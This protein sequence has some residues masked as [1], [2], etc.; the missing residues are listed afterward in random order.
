MSRRRQDPGESSCR[1]RLCAPY[2]RRVLRLIIASLGLAA[3]TVVVFIPAMK[4]GFIWDD[5]LLLT[6]NDMIRSPHGLHDFWLTTKPMDYFPLSSTTLWLEWRLWGLDATGYHVVNVILHALSAIVIWRILRRSGMPGA[7]L[8]AAVFAVHPVTAASVAWIA[9]RKNTLSMLL[10]AVSILI[11]LRFEASGK[12]SSYVLALVMF[13]LALLAKT[14]VVM[15]PPALLVLA[16]WRRRRISRVD[17]RRAVP[18][19]VMSFA[20]GLVTVYYQYHGAIGEQVVRPGGFLSRLAGSGWCVWFYLYK[21][22]LPIRLSMVYPLWNV[23]PGQLLAWLPL[24]G[25]I[26]VVGLAWRYR[27]SWSRP[28]LVMM[29]YFVVMLLP[30][31]GFFNMSFY[32]LSLVADHLQY[33]AVIGP[34]ALVVGAATALGRRSTAGKRIGMAGACITLA[35]LSILTWERAVVCGSQYTLWQDTVRRNPQAWIAHIHL[36]IA[37]AG[38]NRGEEAIQHFRQALR[39]KPDHVGARINLGDALGWLGRTDEAIS[40]LQEALRL[41]PANPKAHVNLAMMLESKGE[42]AEAIKHYEQ[43][44]EVDPD[45]A[46]AHANFGNALLASARLDEAVSHY[47]R[48]LELR[49]ELSVVYFN[50]GSALSSQGKLEEAA[51]SYRQGLALGPDDANAW[52]KLGIVRAR[53]GEIDEAIGHFRQALA[54]SPQHTSAH[55]N[56]GISLENRGKPEEAIEHYRRALQGDPNSVGARYRMSTALAAKGD[57]AEAL[58]S[59][60]LALKQKPDDPVILNTIAWMLATIPDAGLRQPGEA[61]RLAER[62]SELTGRKAAEILD[63]LAAAYAAGGEYRKALTEA[64]VALDLAKTQEAHDLA[65]G[66]AARI[67]LYRQ[68]RPY[69]EP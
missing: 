10:F 27:L 14:S 32:R 61:I 17:I 29:A 45:F 37:L 21:A 19:F 47:R 46:E 34:I 49:P 24:L 9:E 33:V 20:L 26:L 5:D 13:L 44:L 60:R 51:V 66:I 62:A 4:A 59:L 67:E 69:I 64:Q 42:G 1:T 52:C 15:M 58:E 16:W 38:D 2:R 18:F 30:V 50:L 56:L 40:V 68:S 63:T 3:L 12:R 39:L 23:D 7:Y 6:D 8:A 65:A 54:I 36:G 55:Y 28:L 31:L 53:Q 22:L 25:L 11:Y 57:Y 41:D 43:A 35:L 48:A